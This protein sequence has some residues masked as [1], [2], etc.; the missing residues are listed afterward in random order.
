MN[1]TASG[2]LSIVLPFFICVTMIMVLK[3][4][5]ESIGLLDQP[6]ERKQHEGLVPLVGGIAMFTAYSISSLLLFPTWNSVAMVTIAL[7]VVVLGVMD[8]I[9]GLQ[10]RK[11]FLVQIVAA[12]AMVVIGGVKITQLGNI[13]GDGKL[14]FGGFFALVFTVF[15][16]VGVINAMNMVDGADGLAGSLAT[17]SFLALAFAA[18]SA[19]DILEA[20][21]ILVVVGA[22][23]AFLLFNI[24]F[25]GSKAKI[26]MGDAGSMF[27][28][29]LLAWFFIDMSQG[30]EPVLSAVSA[31]WL[32]GLPLL[33]ISA[34]MTRRLFEGRSPFEAGRDHI[35]H[36]M[37]DRGMSVNRAL[38]T[39]LGIHLFFVLV[40]LVANNRPEWEPAFF[41]LFVILVAAHL[42]YTQRFIEVKPNSANKNIRVKSTE[43]SRKS[44]LLD[45]NVSA[46]ASDHT[47]QDTNHR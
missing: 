3:R 6:C 43:S 39:M 40:G 22:L 10:T 12:V 47:V 29:F 24:R 38:I 16:T 4:V 7:V 36:I 18:F 35:H 42:V 44:E 30:E 5:A 41:W 31:G 32:F 17:I 45:R 25:F 9:H 15:S 23:I 8:D 11:R 27:L 19:G 20:Q 14:Y 2:V 21:M 1:V 37:M 28:G 13:F 26:F 46:A 33:D 34:V